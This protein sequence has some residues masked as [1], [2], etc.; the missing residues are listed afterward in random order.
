MNVILCFLLFP[1]V[2]PWTEGQFPRVCTTL[3]CLKSKTCCPIPKHFAKPCGSDGKRGTC[4]ELVTR[5]W[6]YSYSHFHQLHNVDDRHN[7]PG[8]LYNRTCRCKGNYGGYDCGKC[9]FGYH[10]INCTK[11]KTLTRR[12]FLKLS[13]EEKDRYMRYINDSKYFLSDYVVTTTFYKNIN[14]IVEA[15]K[16]PSGLFYNITNYD[17]F[18][19]MHYYSARDTIY[20]HPTNKTKPEIDFA[21]D[22][23][24][25][26]T[27]HRL[28]LLAWERALQVSV[29]KISSG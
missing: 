13:A 19:W 9:K 24:G 2:L 6:N 15:G 18:T 1:A 22:G 27:W 4:E 11:K 21:H 29:Y 8:T 14:D 16:D 23:Q 3:A 5:N 17:L 20:L 26:P 7:W 10:G 25:F 12:N 28:Y